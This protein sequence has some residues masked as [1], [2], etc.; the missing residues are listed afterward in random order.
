MVA[1]ICTLIICCAAIAIYVIHK[2]PGILGHIAEEVSENESD[3]SPYRTHVP[4]APEP[5]HVAVIEPKPE[6]KEGIPNLAREYLKA[7]ER[8]EKQAQG[9][10]M[11]GMSQLGD[12]TRKKSCF[13]SCQGGEDY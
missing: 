5:E 4:M 2:N 3:G 11:R 12:M 7:A 1:V 13:L 6:P 8:L 10:D 9:E